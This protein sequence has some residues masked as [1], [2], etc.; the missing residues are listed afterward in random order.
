MLRKTVTMLAAALTCML[1]LCSCS[2]TG[3]AVSGGSGQQS[4]VAVGGTI[5]S[6]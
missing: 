2:N 5:F 3:V 6:F 4:A 1:L